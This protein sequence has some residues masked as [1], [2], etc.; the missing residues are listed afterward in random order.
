MG[1]K[2]K[3][4]LGLVIILILVTTI[5][6]FVW[7]VKE[8]SRLLNKQENKP[9]ITQP[10]TELKTPCQVDE[11][12]KTYLSYST[13]ETFCAN[14][15]ESNNNIIYHLKPTCDSA[16]W[17]PGNKGDCKCLTNKC[18]W[19]KATDSATSDIEGWQTY[20]DENC[21]FEIKYPSNGEHI[22]KNRCSLLI[23]LDK[24][25]KT[26]NITLYPL[27]TLVEGKTIE[28]VESSMQDLK[29][30]HPNGKDMKEIN[31]QN[32]KILYWSEDSNQG[33]TLAFA[34]SDGKILLVQYSIH[35]NNGIYTTNNEMIFMKILST[36][37]FIPR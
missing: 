16:L 32:G 21:K 17:D 12:C 3:T 11:D 27:D 14:S 31:V 6:V 19:I 26:D 28:S 22:N 29:R 20:R 30:T 23:W 36:F 13:C 1:T 25:S 15:D 10:A 7:R 35:D 37:K 34:I 24:N 4:G 33:P 2:I 8:K 18:Q 9:I 5:G